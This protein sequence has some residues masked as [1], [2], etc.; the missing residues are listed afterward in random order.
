MSE[1]FLIDL[2]FAASKIWDVVPH[3]TQLVIYALFF[4]FN[5]LATF[6]PSCPGVPV[7]GRSLAFIAEDASSGKVYGRCIHGILFILIW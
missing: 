2:D 4:V 6:F 7:A 3:V 1:S 5:M